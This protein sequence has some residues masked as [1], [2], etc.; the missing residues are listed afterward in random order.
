M[1]KAKL[2]IPEKQIKDFFKKWN[3]KEL[4]L[5]GSALTD[6]FNKDSDI[7]ILVSFGKDSR[8]ALFVFDLV[9]M[10]SELEQLFGCDVDLVSSRGLEHSRNSIRRD[11]ILNSAELLY[12]A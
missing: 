4:S 1:N 10:E 7:D 2:E 5:F 6:N 3:V 9:H 8:A 11:A 12:A